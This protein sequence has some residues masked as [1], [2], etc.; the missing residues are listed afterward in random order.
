MASANRFSAAARRQRDCRSATDM[1]LVWVIGS[2]AAL[3]VWGS[4]AW[5]HAFLDEATPR[6]GSTVRVAPS[7]LTLR[8]TQDI[9]PAFSTVTITDAAGQRVDAGKPSFSGNTV[10]VP[11]REIGA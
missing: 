6:V 8:F 11:L 9:E 4:V 3:A 1:R 7:E 5:A 2:T 10:R